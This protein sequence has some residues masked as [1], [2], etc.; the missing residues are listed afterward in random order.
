MQKP[1]LSINNKPSSKFSKS[2]E[3]KDSNFESPPPK[4]NYVLPQPMSAQINHERINHMVASFSGENDRFFKEKKEEYEFLKSKLALSEMT[5]SQL[6]S[7]KTKLIN[8]YEER[9]GE[10]RAEITRLKTLLN[11]KN[12]EIE[13]L[14]SKLIKYEQVFKENSIL[15]EKINSEELDK[16]AIHAELT[17]SRTQIIDLEAENSLLK[18]QKKNLETEVTDMQAFEKNIHFQLSKKNIQIETLQ[19]YANK[20]EYKFKDLERLK[21]LEKNIVLMG[22]EIERLQKFVAK[23]NLENEVLKAKIF[24]YH[25]VV[26]QMSHYEK[27]ISNLALEN[28]RLKSSSACLPPKK[29]KASDSKDPQNVLLGEIERMNNLFKSEN[30]TLEN[31]NK[32]YQRVMKDNVNYLEELKKY[33]SEV[34]NMKLVLRGKEREI[35]EL[36]LSRKMGEVDQMAMTLV[37]KPLNEVNITSRKFTD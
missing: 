25:K 22:G 26:K 30:Q 16:K 24:E 17:K 6:R 7:L 12:L 1:P 3:P 27:T 9:N 14:N 35:E 23:K 31:V 18:S 33:E 10:N 13:V 2:P 21:I 20:L 34:N 5:V 8:E 28:E 19:H 36:K 37:K 32:E 15:Q 11:E 4:E 29:D